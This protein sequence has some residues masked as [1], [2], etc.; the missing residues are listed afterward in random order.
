MKLNKK[1]IEFFLLENYLFIGLFFFT[2]ASIGVLIILKGNIYEITADFKFYNSYIHR[3]T[4]FNTSLIS[5]QLFEASRYIDPNVRE[6]WIPTPFYSILLSKIFL[7]NKF[8]QFFLGLFIGNYQ[9]YLFDKILKKD[10][11]KF[12]KFN[13]SWIIILISLN[14]YFVMDC[15]SF[16]TMSL[17]SFFI[18]FG[19]ASE[20]NF[21]KKLSFCFAAMTRSNFLFFIVS[22]FIALILVNPKIKKDIFFYNLLPSLFVYVIFYFNFYSTYPGNGINYIFM[23]SYQGIDYTLGSITTALNEKLNR[24]ETIDN[25][26]ETNISIKEF[27][28]LITDLHML[29]L[30]FQAWIL[31]I[32]ITLGFIH[33]KVFTSGYKIWLAKI[34]RTAYSCFILIP[35]FYSTNI[36]L[37]SNKVSPNEKFIYISAIFYILLNSLLIADPRYSIGVYFVIVA[38]GIKTLS[39]II[40]KDSK[41]IISN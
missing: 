32:S 40:K 1:E 10:F 19:I 27:F 38:A 36:L 26:F 11:F 22:I 28:N 35:S 9:I 18:I 29:N 5:K 37:I 16:S 2:I 3:Y 12:N 24:P 31:K 34:I 25:I 14:I 20:S 7:A 21:V 15:V 41:D 4:S 13:R 30:V 6:G 8:T 17:A 33:E 23:T 39:M